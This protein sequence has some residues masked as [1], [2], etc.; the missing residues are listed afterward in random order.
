MFMIFDSCKVLKALVTALIWRLVGVLT[1]KVPCNTEQEQ[2]EAQN[3]LETYIQYMEN[4]YKE[5]EPTKTKQKSKK[6]KIKS[7]KLEN[8]IIGIG[9]IIGSIFRRL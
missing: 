6:T 8:G 3:V 4:A 5:E 9:K 2:L 7:S 1:K